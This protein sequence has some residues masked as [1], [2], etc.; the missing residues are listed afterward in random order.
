MES[1]DQPVDSGEWHVAGMGHDPARSY[2]DYST[3]SKE[4]GGM[5][6]EKTIG[7]WSVNERG[8]KTPK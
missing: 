7:P 3:L 4:C 2:Q 6:P 8:A 5:F 1:H